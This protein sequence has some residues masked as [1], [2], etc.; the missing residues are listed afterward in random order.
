MSQRIR[1]EIWKSEKMNHNTVINEEVV[2]NIVI[3]FEF[4][5]SRVMDLSIFKLVDETMYSPAAELFWNSLLIRMSRG[6]S[7]DFQTEIHSLRQNTWTLR[8][9]INT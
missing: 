4:M 6:C 3:N 2:K 9:Q 8:V 1:G 7:S 5:K